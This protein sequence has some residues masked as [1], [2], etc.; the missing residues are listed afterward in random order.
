MNYLCLLQCTKAF[1]ILLSSITVREIGE[2]DP[3]DLSLDTSGTK[4]FSSFVLEVAHILP[5]QTKGCV[6]FLK[7]HLNGEVNNFGT[8]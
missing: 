8:N 3:Q 4:S 2:K 7:C 6:T 1:T 5:M